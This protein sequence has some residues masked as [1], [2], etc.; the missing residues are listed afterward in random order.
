MSSVTELLLWVG[1]VG[2]GMMAGLYFG[3]SSFIMASLA[4]MPAGEGAR[5]MQS[6]NRVILRSSFMVLF[7]AT[8]LV[9]LALAAIGLLQ[10]GAP[11]ATAMLVGGVTYV[12]GMFASTAAF[13]VPLNN[14]LDRAD[15]D[16]TAGAEI[17]AHYLV[18]WTRW[19]HARTVASVLAGGLF[20]LALR[21]VG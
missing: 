7:F 20:I 10:W 9:A 18:V 3:F 4:A 13:N 14:A 2:A 17:W 6:I 15:P 21:Q 5:A 12:L 8:S 16:S 11:G 19:N 1:A